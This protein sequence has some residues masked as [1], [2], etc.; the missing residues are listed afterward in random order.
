MSKTIEQFNSYVMPS[1]GRYDLVLEKGAG[2]T[3]VDEDG[4]EYIDFGSGIGTNSHSATATKNG[5]TLFARR[6]AKSS[7]L[8]TTTTPRFKRIFQNAFVKRRVIPI[9]FSATAAQKLTNAPLSLPASTALT[10]TAKA[11]TI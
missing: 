7:T 10:N 3:A 4:K 6:R 5:L 1:Y 11:D 9:C 8:P 2:R